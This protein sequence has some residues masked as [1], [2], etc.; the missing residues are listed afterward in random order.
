[1]SQRAKGFSFIILSAV[2]FGLVPLLVQSVNACGSNAINTA[3]LRFFLTL[4][5]L[6]VY[7]RIKKVP[8][9]ITLQEARE[10]ILITVFGYGGTTVLLFS[11]YN[12]IPTGIATTIHFVYPVF[13]ILGS[14]IFLRQ[15]AILVKIF[16]AVLCFGGVL[17]FYGGGEEAAIRPI[18]LLLAFASG[19][20]YSIYT[21]GL[22]QGSLR[23]IPSMKLIFYMN[24]V[25]CILIFIMAQ[26]TGDF[27]VGLSLKGWMIAVVMAL[28]IS[29]I[30]VWS[31]QVGAR[32]VGSQNA[33]ILSTFEPITS[34]V[35]G[36]IVYSEAVTISS[37]AGCIL[38]LSS[39]I[40]VTVTKDEPKTAQKAES[41]EE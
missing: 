9:G 8:M 3:F 29:C 20:T 1:M 16:C 26:I 14:V 36:V 2:T 31:Y 22:N 40:I 25:A 33:A 11:A 21:I 35:V 37:I 41:E 23:K 5:P 15:R 39:V 18:G 34:L 30:G 28:C 12:F 6:Y 19:I 24:I 4:V 13:V 7:L 27:T 32:L 17:L 38:I 10:I